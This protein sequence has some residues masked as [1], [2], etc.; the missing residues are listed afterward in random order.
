MHRSGTA[1]D[2]G[3]A[4]AFLASDEASYI[5]GVS[6]R[7]DGGLILPGMMEGH[8]PIQWVRKEWLQKNRDKAMEM[9]EA[10]I[11]EGEADV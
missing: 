3:E 8:E 10:S 7:V 6:L 11:K 4:V 1:R 2:N 9:L 5:T